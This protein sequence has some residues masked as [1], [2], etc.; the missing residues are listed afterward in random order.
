MRIYR[1]SQKIEVKIEGISI[2]ISP[3]SF[4]QKM[5]LQTHMVAASQ[6]DM[7][8]AMKGVVKAL[9]FSMKGIRGVTV[10]DHDGNEVDYELSFEDGELTEDCVNELLNMP[11]ANKISAV[12]TSLLSGIQNQILDHEG[13]PLQ[14]VSVIQPKME[15]KSRSKK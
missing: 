7:D 6:G 8:E 9:K 11:V 14:G 12:C 4:H 15:S 1:T 2:Y 13:K 3:L 10:E 5:E